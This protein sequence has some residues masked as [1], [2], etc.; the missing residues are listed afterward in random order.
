MSSALLVTLASAAVAT[1]ITTRFTSGSYWTNLGANI[2]MLL[3]TA[4]VHQYFGQS[5]ELAK[6]IAGWTK[7]N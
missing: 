5:S 3:F 7:Y 2:F 6:F 1:V 4:A